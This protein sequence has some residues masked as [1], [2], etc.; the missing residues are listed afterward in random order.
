[1][2]FLMSC[3]PQTMHGVVPQS[4]MKNLPTGVLSAD[5]Q[6][7]ASYRDAST[8]RR[9]ARTVVVTGSR[10]DTRRGRPRDAHTRE[11]VEGGV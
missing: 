10:G 4:W 1:M 11:A 5:G 7:L 3:A 6:S 8:T 9:G 2:A